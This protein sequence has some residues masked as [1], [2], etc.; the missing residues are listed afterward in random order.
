MIYL[1]RLWINN[2]QVFV[3]ADDQEKKDAKVAELKEK[4][5][6]ALIMENSV[7]ENDLGS[8]FVLK[9]SE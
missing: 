8:V 2:K 5:P 3:I 6:D 9:G 1:V 4:H 7:I